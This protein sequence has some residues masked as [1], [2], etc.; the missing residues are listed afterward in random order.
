[1][2]KR[3]I[4]KLEN[5]FVLTQIPLFCL[6]IIFIK[7]YGSLTIFARMNIFLVQRWLAPLFFKKLEQRGK[8]TLDLKTKIINEPNL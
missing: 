5:T 2:S 7:I 4:K 1:M 8:P 3:E 6:F